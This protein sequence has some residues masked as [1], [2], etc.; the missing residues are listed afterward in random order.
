MKVQFRI[1]HDQ[2]LALWTAA[3]LIGEM[4]RLEN[5]GGQDELLTKAQILLT[6]FLLGLEPLGP[7]LVSSVPV[8]IARGQTATFDA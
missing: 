7:D 2:L 1:D 8:G 3:R 6:A 5:R 4:R